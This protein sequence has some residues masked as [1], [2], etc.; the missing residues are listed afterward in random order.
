MYC[1]LWRRCCSPEDQMEVALVL[2]NQDIHSHDEEQSTID[3]G[4]SGPKRFPALMH[5]CVGW[6]I[7]FLGCR[8]GSSNH[9]GGDNRNRHHKAVASLAASIAL[10]Y[11]PPVPATWLFQTRYV[12]EQSP[13]NE[14]EMEMALD[15]H[16]K[17]LRNAKETGR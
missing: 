16:C 17:T 1:F 10:M 6:C 4:P 9:L 5:S 14:S 11:S 12:D 15:E 8:V 13:T 7:K 3:R 2:R